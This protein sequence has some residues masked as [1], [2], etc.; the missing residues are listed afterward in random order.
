[1]YH[2]LANIVA[3]CGHGGDGRRASSMVPSGFMDCGLVRRHI[4]VVLFTTLPIPDTVNVLR[5]DEPIDKKMIANRSRD[6]GFSRHPCTT[7]PAR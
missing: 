2:H 4:P 5:R 7:L 6:G 1:M 3:S